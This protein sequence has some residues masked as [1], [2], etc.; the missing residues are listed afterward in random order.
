MAPTAR[1]RQVDSGSVL[2]A[3]LLERSN[4]VFFETIAG[5]WRPPLGRTVLPLLGGCAMLHFGL[6]PKDLPGCPTLS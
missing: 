3:G 6:G 2:L 1:K 4:C 5:L